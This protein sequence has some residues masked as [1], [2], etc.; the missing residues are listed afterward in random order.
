VVSFFS[1]GWSHVR[2]VRLGCNQ[3]SR[4]SSAHTDHSQLYDVWAG[5]H[6][7]AERHPLLSNCCGSMPLALVVQMKVTAKCAALVDVR[8]MSRL[9]ALQS[10]SARRPLQNVC[11]CK[12]SSPR[13]DIMVPQLANSTQISIDIKANSR[14]HAPPHH[15]PLVPLCMQLAGLGEPVA[16][17]QKPQTSAQHDMQLCTTHFHDIC[18]AVHTVTA[19][20]AQAYKSCC[21]RSTHVDQG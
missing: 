12:F 3:L 14:L 4:Q 11:K 16:W 21:W 19:S 6:T 10:S 17:E 15:L 1:D 2:S 5:G 20:S 18:A 9:Q 8:W 7:V 13:A